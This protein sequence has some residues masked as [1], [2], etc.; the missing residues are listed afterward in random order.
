MNSICHASEPLMSMSSLLLT[1]SSVNS[2]F[3]KRVQ[4]F[5]SMAVQFHQRY[6]KE[7]QVNYDEHIY[8]NATI[9]CVSV[10]FATLTFILVNC[11][12]RNKLMWAIGDYKYSSSHNFIWFT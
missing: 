9:F 3:E 6:K 8:C 10:A 2:G 5:H 7:Y 1:L 12:A 4:A 11:C